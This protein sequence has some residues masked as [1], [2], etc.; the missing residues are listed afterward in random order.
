MISILNKIFKPKPTV[1]TGDLIPKGIKTSIKST[2][3]GSS[4][5]FNETWKHIY[6]QRRNIPLIEKEYKK[7]LQY[8]KR[9]NVL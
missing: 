6:S 9:T 3:H 7:Y 4:E 2:N 5:D 1:R 8:Q